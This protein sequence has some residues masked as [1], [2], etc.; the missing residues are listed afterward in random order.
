MDNI[1]WPFRSFFGE[2]AIHPFGAMSSGM[3]EASLL[4]VV[5]IARCMCMAEHRKQNENEERKHAD[6]N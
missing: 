6:C 5:E 1:E 2:D 4:L 3:I